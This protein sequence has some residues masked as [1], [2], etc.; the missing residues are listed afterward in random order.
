MNVKEILDFEE[1][2]INELLDDEEIE[3]YLN[4]VSEYL[5]QKAE[6]GKNIVT[7]KM[8]E[9]RFVRLLREVKRAMMT[10]LLSNDA[11]ALLTFADMAGELTPYTHTIILSTLAILAEEEVI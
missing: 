9:E 10:S 8:S 1:R 11:G 3:K 6:E 4:E 7:S 2:A 5:N